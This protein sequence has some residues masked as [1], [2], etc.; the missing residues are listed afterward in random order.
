MP[1]SNTTDPEDITAAL[2]AWSVGDRAALDRLMPKLYD[3]L[4]RI[5]RR[6]AQKERAGHS[7]QATALVNE[8]YLR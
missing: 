4:H 1:I 2:K 8:A 7:L 6:H 5:A 3:Q